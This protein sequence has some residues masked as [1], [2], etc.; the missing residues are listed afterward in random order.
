[1]QQADRSKLPDQP[2][3]LDFHS[4]HVSRLFGA[5]QVLG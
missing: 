4:H 2:H 5:E 3:I 1:M